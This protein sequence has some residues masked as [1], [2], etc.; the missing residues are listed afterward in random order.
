ETSPVI[1]C[2]RPNDTRIGTVGPA[3]PGVKVR[4]QQEDGYPAG[5]GEIQ[6][7]GTNIMSGYYKNQEATQEIMTDDG[8]L[9]TGDIGTLI[10]GKYL[11]I[12]DRKKEMFKTSGGKYVAPLVV[13]GKFKE[14]KYIENIMVTG[15][16]RKFPGALILPDMMALNEWAA[17]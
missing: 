1:S 7:H 6:V 2:N 13:E 5:E 16:N 4:I 15:E 11:K 8:W 17:A 10:E 12:T 9:K 3:L 14:S